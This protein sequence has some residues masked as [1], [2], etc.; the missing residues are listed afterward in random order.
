MT[1]YPFDIQNCKGTLEIDDS[2][3]RLVPH[4]LDYVGPKDLLKYQL[5]GNVTFIETN[6][7]N[8]ILKTRL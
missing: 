2:F 8:I 7:V 3:V 5:V 6:K 4:F 1:N